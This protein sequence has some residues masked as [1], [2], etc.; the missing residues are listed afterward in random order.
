[1]IETVR[2]FSNLLATNLRNARDAEP[3]LEKLDL[4]TCTLSEDYFSSIEI[5]QNQTQIVITVIGRFYAAIRTTVDLDFTSFC[6][7][8]VVRDTI[9]EFFQL[10]S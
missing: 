8:S 6:G 7:L 1:M 4:E 10:F 2:K 5:K 3:K 9:N